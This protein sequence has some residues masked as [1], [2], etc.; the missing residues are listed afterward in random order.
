M[1]RRE[2]AKKLAKNFREMRG[3]MSLKEFGRKT[4]ISYATLSRIESSQQNVSLQTLE[5]LCI[6]LKCN[7]SDLFK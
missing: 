3:D 1:K 5:Q 4:G 6:S 2:L 7:I